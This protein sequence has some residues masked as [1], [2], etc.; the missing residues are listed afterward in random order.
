MR[1]GRRSGSRNVSATGDSDPP[2]W[3]QSPSPG[4]TGRAAGPFAALSLRSERLLGA[5]SLRRLANAVP[6]RNPSTNAVRTSGP[7]CPRPNGPSPT[8]ESSCVRH[9]RRPTSPPAGAT[10]YTAPRNR[11]PRRGTPSRRAEALRR[12]YDRPARRGVC[13]KEVRPFGWAL[14]GTTDQPGL[15]ATRTLPRISR[16]ARRL[17]GPACDPAGPRG[18]P[19]GVHVRCRWRGSTAA[20]SA[21]L[22]TAPGGSAKC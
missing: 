15:I 8:S 7:T 13:S 11:L 10:P 3:R 17:E 14:S 1:A 21:R 22:W 4:Q 12:R 5:V 6:A 20:G 16:F 18:R 9:G 19:G 2:G